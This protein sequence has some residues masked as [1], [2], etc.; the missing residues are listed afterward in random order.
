MF[1]LSMKRSGTRQ[2]HWNF[3]PSQDITYSEETELANRAAVLQFMS[4]KSLMQR[5][6]LI[7][8]IN[9]LRWFGWSCPFKSNR[10][11]LL[12]GIYRPPNTSKDSDIK[13]GMNFEN[14]SLLNLETIILG[15]F[16]IDCLDNNCDSHRLIKVL[17]SLSFT[18]VMVCVTRPAS[19]KCLDHIWTDKPQYLYKASA[20]DI[21]I[22]LIT[23]QSNVY[24]SL[25]KSQINKQ[26]HSTT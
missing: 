14:A 16:N 3:L 11:L 24:V 17:K 21:F 1:W 25:L 13:L 23:C 7:S 19:G 15:D 20:R 10:K 26:K 9:K 22:S 4:T 18:Q 8:K 12:W 5:G 2:H 6:A